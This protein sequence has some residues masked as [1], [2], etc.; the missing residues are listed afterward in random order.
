MSE[1]MFL[2]IAGSRT[3]NDYHFLKQMIDKELKTKYQTVIVSGGARGADTLAEKYA[4]ENKLE[5]IIFPAKWETFGKSAGYIRN[6]KMH[7]F[8]ANKPNKKVICFWD[9][10][11]KGTAHNFPLAEKFNNPIVIYN[12]TRKECHNDQ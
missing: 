2:L 1:K 11:S 5:T 6:I 3:F 4:K 10:M 8:L 7:E 9:G 12:Y